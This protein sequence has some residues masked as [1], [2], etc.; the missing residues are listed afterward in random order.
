MEVEDEVAE[1]VVVVVEV[2]SLL[3]II[4]VVAVEGESEVVAVIGPRPLPGL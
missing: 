2:S 1:A 4:A 3:T